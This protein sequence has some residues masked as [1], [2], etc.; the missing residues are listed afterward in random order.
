MKR[1]DDVVSLLHR[2]IAEVVPAG[3]R[4]VDAT[5][6]NGLDTVFLARLVGPSGRVWAFDVQPDALDRTRGLLAREGLS[7][8]VCL[9][10]SGHERLNQYVDGPV[11][12]VVFNLGYL[13]R[14]NR[15]VT[16]RAET[17]V[18]ALRQAL[19]ILKK[20][21]RA[22]LVCYP[23]HLEGERET[24]AVARACADLPPRHFAVVSFSVVNRS[25]RPPLAF[26]IEKVGG[27][28]EGQAS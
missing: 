17:T 11:D 2:C 9:V 25:G 14:G 12:A 8:Q 10:R 26:I 15:E 6:G 23:G 20:G 4:A 5:A 18:T 21:G 28:C 27:D 3:G 24:E 22:G 13:P 16:T 1:L 19:E 7:K